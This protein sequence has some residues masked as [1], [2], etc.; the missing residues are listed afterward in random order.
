MLATGEDFTDEILGNMSYLQAAINTNLT[1]VDAWFLANYT[2]SVVYAQT[3]VNANLTDIDTWF[4]N[5]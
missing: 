2:A 1:D 3:M 4:T 5:N